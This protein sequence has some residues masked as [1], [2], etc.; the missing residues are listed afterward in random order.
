MRLYIHQLVAN[1][2]ILH[3]GAGTICVSVFIKH[4]VE[5]SSL[6]LMRTGKVNHNSK[7]LKVLKV[8]NKSTLLCTWL[9]YRVFD[10]SVRSVGNDVILRLVFNSFTE[11]HII[12]EEMNV[13]NTLLV[14]NQILFLFN[15]CILS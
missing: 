5:K 13:S 2:V 6:L 4:C 7:V 3:T 14:L 10:S 9:H 8:L 12:R 11:P 1:F 15:Y